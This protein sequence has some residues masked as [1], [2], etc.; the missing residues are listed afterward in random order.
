MSRALSNRPC[1]HVPILFPH[2]LTNYFGSD[3]VGDYANGFESGECAHFTI[4]A[5]FATQV[6]RPAHFLSG[7]PHPRKFINC[8]MDSKPRRLQTGCLRRCGPTISPSTGRR[9][10]STPSTSGSPPTPSPA[11]R[12]F[13][14]CWPRCAVPARL[15]A[16]HSWPACVP[17]SV[18]L[19]CWYIYVG[20]PCVTR[21]KYRAY[22]DITRE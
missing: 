20:S 3:I 7:S 10:P 19:A 22:P 15:R 2:H 8:I 12:P 14:T 17:V 21:H 18:P 9:R 13:R 4:S 16:R 11:P 6:R 1:P 5:P